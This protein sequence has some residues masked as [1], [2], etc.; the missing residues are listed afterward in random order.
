[1]AGGRKRDIFQSKKEE[2]TGRFYE[3]EV[4]DLTIHSTIFIGTYSLWICQGKDRQQSPFS[5]NLYCREKDSKRKTQK[6]FKDYYLLEDGKGYGI[7]T[8]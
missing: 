6:T 4:Y 2:A 7:N 8:K 3:E 5:Y 1:M